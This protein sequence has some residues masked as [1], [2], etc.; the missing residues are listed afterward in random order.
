MKYKRIAPGADAAPSPEDIL[1]EQPVVS[2]AFDG[3]ETRKALDPRHH[4]GAA[5]ASWNQS[6]SAGWIST[7]L[8]V[9]LNVPIST[10]SQWSR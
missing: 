3:I 4:A 2:A 9:A 7:G 1:R 10:A 6:F 8:P 5:L